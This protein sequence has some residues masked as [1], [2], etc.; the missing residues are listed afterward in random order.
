M[1]FL[2]ELVNHLRLTWRLFW[3]DEV[4]WWHRAVFFVPLVYLLIPFRYD[5]F[6][7][8]APII[9]L[10]DDWFLALLC[11]YVFTFLCPRRVVR[12][13]R[14]AIALSD[15]DPDVRGR[16]RG[17]RAMLETLSAT[18]RL[19]MYRHPRESL[20]LALSVAILVGLSALGG[21]VLGVLLIVFLGASYAL[22]RMGHEQV[23]RGAIQVSHESYPRVQS[24]LDR[25]YGHLPYVS[26]NV[27]VVESP[28]LNAY[29][30]GID[31]PYTMV[32][33]S[34]LIEAL[35]EDELVAVIGHELG[36]VLYEHT[37]L[38]SL[39]GGM[40]YPG[41]LASLLWALVYLRWRRLAER[42]A[43]RI[44]LLACGQLDVVIRALIKLAAGPDGESV[45]MD[46]IM[47]QVYAKE[48]ADLLERL[49]G[50]VGTHPQLVTRLRALVDFDAELFALDVEDWLAA[51][52]PH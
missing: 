17:D 43:D 18:E 42:T 3:D 10:L 47:D 28:H 25:C 5:I 48:R 35:D 51:D 30:W 46:G 37:F 50:L 21:L 14:G 2:Y 23:L 33:Y 27:V 52:G 1:G 31:S 32:L 6:V 4:R 26:M 12:R 34:G 22:A 36:H 45:D 49:G 40:L 9:G 20:A 44:S 19:E 24:C 38:S 8:L 29:T 16:A 11:S 7:D 15:P 13:H 41:R 39:M